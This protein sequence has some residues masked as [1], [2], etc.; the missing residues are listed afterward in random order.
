M[1][2]VI[3][4]GIVFT[5]LTGFGITKKILFLKSLKLYSPKQLLEEINE[6][7]S[8]I[9][10]LS[11]LSSD[12]TEELFKLI[13]ERISFVPEKS[14]ESFL[15]Q[16]NSSI[17]DKEDT[18]YLALALSKAIPIWSNDEHFKRQSVVEVFNTKELIEKLKSAGIDLE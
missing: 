5:G 9:L 7:K 13:K 2:L 18:S 8:R 15:E 14:F 11:S 17:P 1:E 10:K 6:H 3:D 16:A 12:E 4:A